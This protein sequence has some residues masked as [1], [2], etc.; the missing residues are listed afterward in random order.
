[1]SGM[2]NVTSFLKRYALP[3]MPYLPVF[4]FA[5]KLGTAYRIASGN[6]LLQKLMGTLET[7]GAVISTPMPSF[8]SFDLT[9]GAA[10]AIIVF[11]IVYV[12]KQNAKLYRKDVEYGSARWGAKRICVS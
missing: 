5:N 6:D 4:W 7:F 12:K 1:M 9:V 11:V 3:N 10:G 8:D 2:A